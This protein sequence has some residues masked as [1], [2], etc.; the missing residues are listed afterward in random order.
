[1]VISRFRPPARL[2]RIVG[3]TVILV[4][5][6]L[7]THGTFAGTGDEPHYAMI[8][9]SLAFD[10]DLD[11]ANNYADSSNLVSHGALAPERHAIAG[12]DGRLRPVHDIG[13]PLLFTPYF[14]A[15]H[16]TAARA[17]ASL[18]PGW[19]K[20]AR[21][22][23]T[24]LLRHFLSLAMAA[25][26]AWIAMQL[27]DLGIGLGASARLAAGCALLLALSPPLLAHGFLFFTEIVSA[28]IV[29]WVFRRLRAPDQSQ[30]A[31]LLAGAMTGLLLLVHAR[32]AGLVAGLTILAVVIMRR[33]P[34]VSRSL[35]LF[36]AG[37][38]ALL[39]V[40]T[41][42]TYHFWGTLITTPHAH[43][44][45]PADLTASAGEVGGRLFGWLFDQEH[46]LFFYAPI[47]LLA[48][49]GL[50][51]LW[52][53]DRA[54]T[55]Q[56]GGLIAMYVAVMALPI[57]NPHGW[58][59]GWSPA[60]RF[61]V[62]IVPLLAYPVLAWVIAAHRSVLFAALA[63]LQIGLNALLWQNPKLLWNEGDG[64]SALLTYLGG[65]TERLVWMLPG[66]GGWMTPALAAA[67][68]VIGAAWLRIR[69][70]A[71]SDHR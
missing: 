13:M 42:V 48:P 50:V 11:L 25:L 41:A 10:R 55:L 36:G 65:G 43:I 16:V 23:D 71:D 69:R 6:G 63:L 1:M 24:V 47:Y 34:L 58:R 39:I 5:W 38:I 64:S 66:E 37:L 12:R 44:A 4:M 17:A 51:M 59:G 9:H 20:R 21:L 19:M 35:P 28:A 70:S 56:A 67:V 45:A 61:L 49:A 18:P 8:A 40:R 14:A 62:P 15:A 32:N 52:R 31:A 7:L 27:F 53:R 3:G 57:L 68:F 60:A 54:M 26:L 22:T 2:R 46:G 29:L 30:G 33:P